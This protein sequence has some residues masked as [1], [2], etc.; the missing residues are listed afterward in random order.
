M[1]VIQNF[2]KQYQELVQH[3]ANVGN[4]NNESQ[5]IVKPESILNPSIGFPIQNSVE[6]EFDEETK[7][8]W[9]KELIRPRGNSVFG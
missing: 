8:L 4:E 5:D 2:Q 6:A 9:A 7:A 3:K 1:D